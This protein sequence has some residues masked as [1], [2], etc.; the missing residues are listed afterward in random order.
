MK[1]VFLG[2][3]VMITLAFFVFQFSEDSLWKVEILV[4][5]GISASRLDLSALSTRWTI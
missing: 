4:D 5:R 3:K 1:K 2:G